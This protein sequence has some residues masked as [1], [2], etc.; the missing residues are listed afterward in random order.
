MKKKNMSPLEN[1]F[2]KTAQLTIFGMFLEREKSII[3]QKYLRVLDYIIPVWPEYLCRFWKIILLLGKN[4][5]TN[6]N[7]CPE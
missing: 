7:V 3:S 4:R 2:G 1:L 5:E 6:P